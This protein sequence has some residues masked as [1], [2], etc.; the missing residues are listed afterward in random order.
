MENGEPGT[1][2]GEPANG[3]HPHL[4]VFHSHFRFPIFRS[5]CLFVRG[6]ALVQLTHHGN[7]RSLSRPRAALGPCHPQLEHH[8]PQSQL[9]CP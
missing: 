7:G 4:P 8:D 1:G 3:P 9:R 5:L 6:I 2:N